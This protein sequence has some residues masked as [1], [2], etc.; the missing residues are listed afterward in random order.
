MTFVFW[1]PLSLDIPEGPHFRSRHLVLTKT[2]ITVKLVTQFLQKLLAVLFLD[3]LWVFFLLL[4][5]KDL[6]TILTYK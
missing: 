3:F 4:M 6:Q 2:Q 1:V 5:V